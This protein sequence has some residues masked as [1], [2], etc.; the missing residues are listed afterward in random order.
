MSTEPGTI[1][2]RRPYLIAALVVIA[3]VG[4]I[5]VVGAERLAP[6]TD[7]RTRTIS[8][9]NETSADIDEAAILLD[10]RYLSFGFISAGRKKSMGG[11][12]V[13]AGSRVGAVYR[14]D[15]RSPERRFFYSGTAL[16]PLMAKAEEL[17]ISRCEQ[18][19]IR[20]RLLSTDTAGR[21]VEVLNERFHDSDHQ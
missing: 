17:E 13:A 12:R 16:I 7:H 1:R 3:L 21:E 14:V 18:G 4:L 10:D 15:E 2:T 11:G 9:R 20:F 19:V 8:F 6:E 5:V